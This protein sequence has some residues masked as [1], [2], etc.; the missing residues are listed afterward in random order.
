ML[1]AIYLEGDNYITAYAF[2]LINAHA[3]I[4]LPHTHL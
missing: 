4:G 1:K 3:P 2:D